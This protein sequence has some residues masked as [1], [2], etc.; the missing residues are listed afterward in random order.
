[1]RIL[2]ILTNP[3]TAAS[4]LAATCCFASRVGTAEIDLLFPRPDVD[5]DFM[6]TEDVYTEVQHRSFEALQ[7]QLARQL[8]Q[9]A[10]NWAGA[11]LPSLRQIRGKPDAVAGEAAAGANLVILGAP[12]GELEANAILGTLL[13]EAN[14]PVLLV[15]R[16]LPHSFGQH[17]AIAWHSECDGAERAV[18]SMDG[19]LIGA[20]HITVLIADHGASS[21]PP[22]E[23]LL[24]QLH[25]AGKRAAVRHFPLA[26]RHIGEAL[27]SEA[28]QVKADLLVMGAFGH[29]RLREFIFGGATIEILRDFDLPVL[30]RH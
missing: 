26:K 27:L 20:K 29:S 3:L 30:M 18:D 17:I 15:P 9:E 1:M 16:T 8:G 10:A 21:S 23:A 25:E 28:R 5:P 4:V 22:P 13:L 19:L 12:H 7:D 2:A 14:K 11:G 6:P 24:R